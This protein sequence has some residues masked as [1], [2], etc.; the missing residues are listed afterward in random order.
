M[1]KGRLRTGKVREDENEKRRDEYK[2]NKIHAYK[3]D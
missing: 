1:R 3:E 2:I